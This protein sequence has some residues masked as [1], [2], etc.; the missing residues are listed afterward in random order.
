M[1]YKKTKEVSDTYAYFYFFPT[2]Q[3]W[4]FSVVYKYA[5][6]S[7]QRRER[8]CKWQSQVVYQPLPFTVSV[9]VWPY[10]ICCP[11][12]S[13]LSQK[14]SPNKNKTLAFVLTSFPKRDLRIDDQMSQ[15]KGLVFIGWV[16]LICFALKHT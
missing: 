1:I 4:K 14:R 7:V 13:P 9:W 16:T 10:R 8:G 6:F 12:L 15:H 3:I 11:C 2:K 5:S